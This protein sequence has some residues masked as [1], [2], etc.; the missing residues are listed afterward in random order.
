MGGLRLS[1]LLLAGCLTSHPMGPILP[2]STPAEG[3]KCKA[4][5]SQASPLVTEWPAS[6]KANLEALLMQGTVAVA[7]SGCSM[8]VLPQ[9]RPKGHY[10]WQH[11]TPTADVLSINNEDELYS[12]LPLGAVSLEAELKRSGNLEVKTVVSGQV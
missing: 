12:K 7:Y 8:R 5:A 2:A 11:T 4:A 1:P 10:N 6:E 9:C 3:A